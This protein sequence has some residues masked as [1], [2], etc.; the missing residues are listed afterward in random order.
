M[1]SFVAG[2]AVLLLWEYVPGSAVIHEVFPAVLL[3]FGAYAGVASL[4]PPA[5][6][7]TVDRLFGELE[8]EALA[9][10]SAVRG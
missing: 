2:L 10:A 7:E 4:T 6:V 3:S 9:T 1:S 5:R 8:S